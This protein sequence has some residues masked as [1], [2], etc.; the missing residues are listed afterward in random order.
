MFEDTRMSRLEN[1][2][3][4]LTTSLFNA[5]YMKDVY[6]KCIDE[7]SVP[8]HKFVLGAQCECAPPPAWMVTHCTGQ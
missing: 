8:V 1:H 2:C 5:H 3:L 7:V 4:D 6:L